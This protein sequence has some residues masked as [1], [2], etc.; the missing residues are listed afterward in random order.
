M[1]DKFI[2]HMTIPMDKILRWA[3]KFDQ[4]SKSEDKD[5]SRLR[6]ERWLL[7]GSMQ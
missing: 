7:V 3:D 5:C 2:G 4:A 6:E 1:C